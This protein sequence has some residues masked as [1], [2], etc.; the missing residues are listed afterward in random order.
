MA[1]D[2][3]YAEIDE[4][5][6]VSRFLNEYW[7]KDHAYVRLPE[8]FDWT[9]RRTG[10]WDQ[11]GYSFALAETKGEIVG[12]L[13][14]IPFS[15]NCHGK[16]SRAVWTANYMVRPEYRGG[17]VGISLL[18][19]FWRP[20][21]ETVVSFGITPSVTPL[22]HLLR[23]RVMEQIPRHFMVLPDAQERAAHL[24][25][26]AQ[27]DWSGDRA[28]ALVREFEATPRLSSGA[29]A[30][31]LLP[32]K[33][34]ELDWPVH[35]T[36]TVG[37]ARDVDYLTWRY[38]KHPVFRYRLIGAS[39]GTRT[40]LLIWRLEKIHHRTPQGVDEVDRIGRLVEFLPTSSDNA[41]RLL[42]SFTRELWNSRAL[43]A[44]FYGYHGQIRQW[45]Q[46][47]GFRS[48]N[49]HPDGQMIPSR[50]QPLDGRGG[51]I[52]SAFI[53]PDTVPACGLNSGCSWY[54]TKSDADQDR[55]N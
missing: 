8:L 51:G 24:L 14:G 30:M 1:I 12:I 34:D 26:L 3:R 41:N 33:W 5:H 9:F 54:W 48:V 53:A 35:S 27:P 25:R 7:A 11:E 13:G 44:D 16:T 55:P 18:R 2:F 52:C 47:F 19:M 37:A 10:L 29:E 6:R 15:F 39:D 32:E 38:L 50:F 17:S 49:G 23:W 45:L 22:Y 42:T 21:F 28:R 43:G 4:Y 31:E 46:E 36:G 40:G 20:P